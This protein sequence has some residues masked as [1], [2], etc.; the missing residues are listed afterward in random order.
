MKTGVAHYWLAGTFGILIVIIIGL[1][2]LN[3]HESRQ[4]NEETHRITV[5]EW[6][7]SH[8]A[9]EAMQ[10]SALNSRIT[11]EMFLITNPLTITNLLRE[12]EENSAQ[13]TGLINQLSKMPADPEEHHWLVAVRAA[14]VAYVKS[15]LTS[16]DLL[17]KDNQ[18]DLARKKLT[19]DALPKLETYHTAW[20]HY[21]AYQDRLIDNGGNTIQDRY[22]DSSQRNALLLAFG[23]LLAVGLA[24]YATLRLR[25]A[26]RQIVRFTQSLQEARADLE[27]KVRQR[28]VDLD[29][30]N[31]ALQAENSV[32]RQAE[33]QLRHTAAELEKTNADLTETAAQAQEL[34]RQADRA[35]QAKSQFLANMSHEI[36]TPMNAI[37]G[38]S[39]LL[40]DSSLD[41][42]QREFTSTIIQSSES[43]LSLINDVLDLSKIESNQMVLDSA[44]FDLRQLTDDVL[45]LLAPRAQ[46]RSVELTAIL[47]PELPAQL[48][49][50]PARLR[51]ILVNLIGNGIKFTER[52]DVTLRVECVRQDEHHT[53]LRFKVTDTGIGIAPEVQATLFR[54]F[55]Q[56]DASTTRKYGGTG[57]GLFISKRLVELMSGRIGLESAPGQGSTFWF[58]VE[59]QT[60]KTPVPAPAPANIALARLR[61]II[62]DSHPATRESLRAMVQPWGATLYESDNGQKAWEQLAFLPTDA[63]SPIVLLAGQLPDMTAEELAMRVG[64]Q[65]RQAYSVQLCSVE[66][67]QTILPPG[68]HARLLKPVKQ[69]QLYNTLL[70]AAAGAHTLLATPEPPAAP[71]TP[72]E[73]PPVPAGD[74]KLLVVEDNNINRR[75]IL[76]MLRKL[77][78]EPAM[79]IN[80]REA[81]EHW[82]KFRPDVILMDCQ[83]PVMDGYEATREIRRREA[84]DPGARP[85]HIIAVTANAMK[86]DRE[87]C[88]EAGMDDC[89]SKPIR[90]ELLGTSL[91]KVA[92]TLKTA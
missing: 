54:A 87:K 33:D 80:G 19:G 14:R 84:G 71:A 31:Q 81:V 77:G 30:A 8:L 35:N 32:R 2:V 61:L 63:G 64:T 89:L 39:Y 22:R 21:M 38:M 51:Q 58:E 67:S 57:L 76:L 45:S 4:V 85:V 66:T 43:L 70:T 82:S 40:Q 69:S 75:L 7:K 24:T 91:A 90:M 10:L 74:I 78:Y 55:T 20:E 50:D 47:P 92:S 59:F 49:G 28:T 11:M 65:H 29:N 83:L 17:L 27:N 68:V 73:P 15:Y 13:I 37:M 12:R 26:G 52:G 16:L 34:A 60:Q 72:P 79:V 1:G 56:A 48:V 88:L 18:P 5:V 53:R 46:A 62:A 41:A 9:R 44:P 86:G 3:L 36:R 6:R 25:T 23:V 42:R